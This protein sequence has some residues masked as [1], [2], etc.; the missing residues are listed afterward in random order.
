MGTGRQSI[1]GGSDS[2]GVRGRWARGCRWGDAKTRKCRVCLVDDRALGSQSVVIDYL[3]LVAPDFER[4]IA[5]NDCGLY[6]AFSITVKAQLQEIPQRGWVTIGRGT[7]ETRVHVYNVAD[8]FI[9][10]TRALGRLDYRTVELRFPVGWKELS[11][12]LNTKVVEFQGGQTCCIGIHPRK[13]LVTTQTMH[14]AS[15]LFGRHNI[16]Q[17]KVAM[18][19]AYPSLEYLEC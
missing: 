17:S 15:D 3:N 10:G 1:G 18:A 9:E 11:P 4:V 13:S 2:H 5:Q 6:D 12:E 19:G 7:E 8:P 14:Y 16:F